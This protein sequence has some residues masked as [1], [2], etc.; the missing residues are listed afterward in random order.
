MTQ[1]LFSNLCAII[2]PSENA[3][4]KARNDIVCNTRRSSRSTRIGSVVLQ[5]A[6]F[7][8]GTFG[9]FAPGP[10]VMKHHG[11]TAENV[12]TQA[13]LVLHQLKEKA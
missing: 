9:A 6:A 5:H 12:C 1:L 13:H 4:G 3:K 7:F 11:F 2:N 10:V 8:C